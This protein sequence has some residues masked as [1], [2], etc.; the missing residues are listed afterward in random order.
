[1][2]FLPSIDLRQAGAIQKPVKRLR[3]TFFPKIVNCF[4]P[5]SI[6][7]KS[8]ILDIKQGSEY[9]SERRHLIEQEVFDDLSVCVLNLNL[10]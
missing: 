9:T 7:T 4:Q 3:C 2:F 8:S 5:L 6:S 10:V 1:M